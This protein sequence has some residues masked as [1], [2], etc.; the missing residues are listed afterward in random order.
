[1]IGKVDE[2]GREYYKRWR[3]AALPFCIH[4]ASYLFQYSL[5]PSMFKVLGSGTDKNSSKPRGLNGATRSY[6]SKRTSAINGVGSELGPKKK[7]AGKKK[8]VKYWMK[9]G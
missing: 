9:T 1:M 8:I 5:R 3:P 4:T 2:Q 6:T 7:N